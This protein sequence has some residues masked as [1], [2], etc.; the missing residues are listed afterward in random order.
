MIV[1]IL[2]EIFFPLTVG[3]WF[4]RRASKV[5]FWITENQMIINRSF[6]WPSKL[7]GR[8]LSSTRLHRLRCSW[9]ARKYL[10]RLSVR[11]ALVLG[12]SLGPSAAA[13]EINDDYTPIVEEID[14]AL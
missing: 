14:R 2:M 3:F 9:R 4:M 7:W 10:T 11:L 5:N 13:A 1:T 12:L 8:F 6:P